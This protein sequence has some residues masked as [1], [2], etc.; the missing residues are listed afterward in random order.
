M[1]V[2]FARSDRGEALIVADE[3]PNWSAIWVIESPAPR[4]VVVAPQPARA[5]RTEVE[6]ARKVGADVV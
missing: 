6:R 3:R 5:T 1:A 2:P 4:D